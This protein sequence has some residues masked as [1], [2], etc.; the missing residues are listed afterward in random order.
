[1]SDINWDEAPEGATHYMPLS[2]MFC[3]AWVKDVGENSYS[4]IVIDEPDTDWDTASFSY[5]KTAMSHLIEKPEPSKPVFTQAMADK[6]ELPSVGMECLATYTD[7]RSSPENVVIECVIPNWVWVSF[8][9]KS[10]EDDFY[11]ISIPLSKVKFKA[12]QTDEDKAVEDMVEH[13]TNEGIVTY[14]NIML[15]I[16]IEKFKAG[17]IHGVTFKGES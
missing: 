1:M 15:K 3:E 7:W 2:E 10:V 13:L 6:G 11:C 5:P 4:Y 9:D 17:K 14:D 12:I 16:L 8:P